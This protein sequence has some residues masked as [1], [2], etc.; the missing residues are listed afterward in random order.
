VLGRILDGSRFEEFKSNYGKTLV[1][2]EGSRGIFVGVG[3]RSREACIWVADRVYLQM[4]ERVEV[5]QSW[6]MA[7]HGLEQGWKSLLGAVP[8]RCAGCGR[9]LIGRGDKK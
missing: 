3:L 6:D 8:G 1:T 5:M 2:G 7:K 4:G 9:L